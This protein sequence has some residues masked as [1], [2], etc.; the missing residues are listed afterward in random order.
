[1]TQPKKTLGD[2]RK[3]RTPAATPPPGGVPPALAGMTGGMPLMPGKVLLTPMEKAE[4]AKHGWKEGDPIPANLPNLYA[5]VKAA[6]L[7]AATLPPMDPAAVAAHNLRMPPVVQVADLPKAKQSELARALDE[8]KIQA[9]MIERRV[10]SQVPGAGA[11]VNEAIQ[12]ALLNPLGKPGSFVVEDDLKPKVSAPPQAGPAAP[13]PPDD[14]DLDAR[15][16][17]GA[18][19]HPKNCPHCGFDLLKKELVEATDEDKLR[20]LVAQEGGKRFTK[21]YALNA[22]RITVTFRTL[23]SK[24]SD[25]AWRQVAVDGTRDI[26]ERVPET[27][28]HHW[29]NL[30]VY[31]MVM[32][33]ERLWT[34]SEGPQDNPPLDEWKVDKE[35]YPGPNTKVYALL[36]PVTEALFP[37]ESLRRQLGNAFHKFAL[38]VELLEANA[39][40]DPF[41]SGIGL[42]S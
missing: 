26:R 11:G 10:S 4:L 30:M 16:G 41:W 7:D 40:N 38:L 36:G 5:G 42:Q 1:M 24:E 34:L 20:W 15:P 27:E 17:A 13:L 18:V 37:T 8:A 39:D 6:E 22:G 9:E 32:S 29:R 2:A 35:D 14:R 25:V 28:D 31:R 21:D 12:T 23:T 19:E 3:P 33:I